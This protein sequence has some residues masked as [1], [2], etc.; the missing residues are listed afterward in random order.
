M[1]QKTN[2]ASEIRDQPTNL[3]ICPCCAGTG[4]IVSTPEKNEHSVV[5]KCGHKISVYSPTLNEWQLNVLQS[6]WNMS[7]V[8]MELSQKVKEALKLTDNSLLVFDISNYT[9][10]NSFNTFLDA[11]T[12]MEQ[13]FNKDM[14][15]T[16]LFQLKKDNYL[17]FVM[18]SDDLWQDYD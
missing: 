5:C 6:L 16:A 12:F 9:L 18:V 8:E 1:D 13:E 2:Q 11:I 15:R 10:L 3:N 4:E 14:S 7:L 17:D